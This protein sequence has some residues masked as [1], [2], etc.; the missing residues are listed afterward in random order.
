MADVIVKFNPSS[1]G[2]GYERKFK[3]SDF[4]DIEGAKA[5]SFSEKNLFL[6]TVPEAVYLFLVDHGEPVQAIDADGNVV[7]VERPEV[8]EEA[9]AEEQR[10]ADL[11]EKI[12]TAPTDPAPD[13]AD[14]GE[15]SGSTADSTAG[16]GTK[17]TRSTT[18]GR[19]R[20]S[21]T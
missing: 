11:A 4:G 3:A 12:G 14:D 21:T 9:S 20:T 19:G 6:E 18:G 16:D 17:T 5:L 15:A 8:V 10:L 2:P 7:E 13:D 1:G